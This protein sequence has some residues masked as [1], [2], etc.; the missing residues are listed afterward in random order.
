MCCKIGILSAYPFMSTSNDVS[1][2]SS[3]SR[4]SSPEVSNG[5]HILKGIDHANTY[6]L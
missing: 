1:E 3:K 5:K 4:D 2:E 6:G